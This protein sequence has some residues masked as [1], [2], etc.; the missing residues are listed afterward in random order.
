MTAASVNANGTVSADNH[1][2]LLNGWASLTFDAVT[3]TGLR[4]GFSNA[5]PLQ[6]NH[7]R[8]YE[9]EVYGR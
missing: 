8:V 5:T 9:F 7:Y 2:S 1:N 4:V 6:Q 3:A